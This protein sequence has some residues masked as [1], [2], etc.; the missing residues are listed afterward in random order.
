MFSCTSRQYGGCIVPSKHC[1]FVLNFSYCCCCIVPSV[2]VLAVL[3]LRVLWWLHCTFLH[4]NG[5]LVR[6]D[7]RAVVLHSYIP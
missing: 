2:T 1:S 6:S 7:I 4:C 5:C 3:R